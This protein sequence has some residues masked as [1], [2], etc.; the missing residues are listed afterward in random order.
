MNNLP[1]DVGGVIKFIGCVWAI[2]FIV[3]A[4]TMAMS[5]LCKATSFLWCEFQENVVFDLIE[6]KPVTREEN[7]P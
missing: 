7:V 2:V 4:T 1:A 5:Y 6:M 3:I